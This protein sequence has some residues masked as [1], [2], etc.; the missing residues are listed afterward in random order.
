M[1]PPIILLSFFASFAALFS[2][3]YSIELAVSPLVIT[4]L[5]AIMRTDYGRRSKPLTAPARSQT[6]DER[7]RLAA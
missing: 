6:A 1:K 3:S 5:L 2:L 4:G 7:L